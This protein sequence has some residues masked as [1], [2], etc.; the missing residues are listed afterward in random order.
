MCI[1]FSDPNLTVCDESRHT[2][3]SYEDV[4]TILFIL[5]WVQVI[6]SFLFW[7]QTVKTIE[8]KPLL[9]IL[10]YIFCLLT[11]SEHILWFITLKYK[12]F[13]HK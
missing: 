3:Q 7:E 5:A 12:D 13:I 10:V 4:L 2:G 8:R 11:S 9:I 6:K 1:K